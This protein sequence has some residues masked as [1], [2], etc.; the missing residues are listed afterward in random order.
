ME[1]LLIKLLA[2]PSLE[3]RQ[4]WAEEICQG[5]KFQ[6]FMQ[7]IIRR[8]DDRRISGQY[9]VLMNF[10]LQQCNQRRLMSTLCAI[11]DDDLSVDEQ[12]LVAQVLYS[13][14]SNVQ[15]SVATK[16]IQAPDTLRKARASETG[17]G[18]IM[19][20]RVP[21]APGL[22]IKA[23]PQVGRQAGSGETRLIDWQEEPR[24]EDP[25]EIIVWLAKTESALHQPVHKREECRRILAHTRPL[26]MELAESEAQKAEDK[27]HFKERYKNGTTESM[28]VFQLDF[29]DTI[30]YQL[31]FMSGK[32]LDPFLE[33]DDI[34]MV[35]DE[36]PKVVIQ[37]LTQGMV[38]QDTSNDKSKG[39]TSFAFEKSA[40]RNESI[41]EYILRLVESIESRLRRELESDKDQ[42][43]QDQEDEK[44]D[45]SGNA[46]KEDPTG[47]VRFMSSLLKWT[48]VAKATARNLDSLGDG[49]V[50]AGG[51]DI[52]A[53]ATKNDADQTNVIASMSYVRLNSQLRPIQRI[54]ALA[55]LAVAT[56]QPHKFSES[57]ARILTLVDSLDPT[58]A[59]SMC[60]AVL[61][62]LNIPRNL[63]RFTRANVEKA[64]PTVKQKKA[65]QDI[66]ES[67]E[68]AS[69][70]IISP[71]LS[72]LQKPETSQEQR[73]FIFNIIRQGIRYEIVSAV[74]FTSSSTQKSTK[75]KG[76]GAQQLLQ[77]LRPLEKSVDRLS[78]LENFHD[79][80]R[81]L[82]VCLVSHPEGH[83]MLIVEDVVP[84]LMRVIGEIKDFLPRFKDA[85][86]FKLDTP[87][88]C[89]DPQT[90][91]V[92]ANKYLLLPYVFNTRLFRELCGA[93]SNVGQS[94]LLENTNCVPI[95]QLLAY[96]LG[97]GLRD[98]YNML[99]D[100]EVDTGTK[101]MSL[102]D[103]VDTDVTNLIDA[104]AHIATWKHS[105][106]LQAKILAG[107][108]YRIVSHI[109]TKSSDEGNRSQKETQTV[110]RDS[111]GTVW[112]LG[113][114]RE[115]CS[116]QDSR[117]ERSF[118][119]SLWAKTDK[120]VKVDLK[121]EWDC[122]STSMSHAELARVVKSGEDKLPI[123]ASFKLLRRQ[124][125]MAFYARY[126]EERSTENYKYRTVRTWD[127]RDKND[128]TIKNV[129]NHKGWAYFAFVVT[130]NEHKIRGDLKKSQDPTIREKLRSASQR[131]FGDHVQK[132]NFLGF[133]GLQV[134]HGDTRATADLQ[135]LP[136]V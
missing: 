58:V 101:N 59:Q 120:D 92:I 57:L 9:R 69:S 114:G 122:F 78:E 73:A 128:Q 15:P 127:W 21:G 84:K 54:L 136:P 38:S 36:P 13:C 23:V 80:F 55:V 74:S 43:D 32:R 126:R 18:Q 99:K 75:S 39:N 5:E 45:E 28:E 98:L 111:L 121:I 82:S 8:K 85:T 77:V 130:I 25:N 33:K 22:T 118:T 62:L 83:A 133:G 60:D 3:L 95:L 70:R 2:G 16:P 46:A 44:Q 119:F 125:E 61:Q 108:D 48:R 102:L 10:V 51:Q 89:I 100:V 65:V 63:A 27:A 24:V 132:W 76:S 14:L 86:A 49:Q 47:I 42:V 93:I 71:L 50:A 40:G 81:D 115:D 26:K 67:K 31:Q 66:A 131:R 29:Q 19:K 113:R 34:E 112:D 124:G 129:L 88:V 134:K 52:D 17:L 30:Y 35:S 117:S 105:Q 6:R 64:V 68:P 53:A 116:T 123:E 79:L 20:L 11:R 103:H 87:S 91:K 72:I 90:R 110:F 7:Q 104:M 37:G 4:H 41:I 96:D 109:L 106:I 135:I 1:D 56:K 12:V 97:D 107:H 94:D